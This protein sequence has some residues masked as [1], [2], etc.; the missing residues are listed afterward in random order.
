MTNPFKPY[1]IQVLEIRLANEYSPQKLSELLESSSFL[2]IEYTNYGYY[3]SV[4]NPGFGKE[5]RV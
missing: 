5:R 4:E 3:V 1:E 2:Q